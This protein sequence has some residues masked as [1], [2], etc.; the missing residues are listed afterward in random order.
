MAGSR[1]PVSIRRRI[2]PFTGPK[3]DLSL[4]LFPRAQRST[5]AGFP[6]LE[7]ALASPSVRRGLKAPGIIRQERRTRGNV[8]MS[9]FTRASVPTPRQFPPAL[10]RASLPARLAS[11]RVGVEPPTARYFAPLL[12]S[13]D[14]RSRGKTSSLIGVRRDCRGSPAAAD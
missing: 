5:S 12:V 1:T 3:P 11:L 13:G 14:L 6:L 10:L 9:G 4:S 7:P 2:G 8:G